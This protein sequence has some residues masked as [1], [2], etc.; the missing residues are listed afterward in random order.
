M[1]LLGLTLAK[2]L[3][4]TPSIKAAMKAGKRTVISVRV[5]R[6]AEDRWYDLGPVS[7]IHGRWAEW[8][9]G[10]ASGF[11]KLVLRFRHKGRDYERPNY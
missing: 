8:L 10:I 1:T 4:D 5:Y 3:A 6:A 9:D 11:P 2:L 7:N